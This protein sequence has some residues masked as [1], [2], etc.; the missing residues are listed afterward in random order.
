MQEDFVKHLNLSI[1]DQLGLQEALQAFNSAVRL[2]PNDYD[3]YT[4]LGLSL[5]QQCYPD[6]AI[7]VYNHLI[8]L[9][10]HPELFCHLGNALC[11]INHYE[12][13]INA[14]REALKLD[15]SLLTAYVDLAFALCLCSR[16]EEA[17]RSIVV[18]AL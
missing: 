3:A 2:N 4:Q 16:M 10:P 5:Y 8:P 14:Y 15:P 1:S 18:K 13:A 11:L 12:D 7:M 6:P 17:S 9:R